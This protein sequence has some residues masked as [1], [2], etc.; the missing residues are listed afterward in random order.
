MG[1]CFACACARASQARLLFKGGD[2]GKTDI[3]V[4]IW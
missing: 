4:A 2:F 3:E 1:D